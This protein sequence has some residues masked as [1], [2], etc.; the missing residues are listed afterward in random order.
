MLYG[1]AAAR[2]DRTAWNSF[3]QHPQRRRSAFGALAIAWLAKHHP[4]RSLGADAI[5]G[6]RRFSALV[7]DVSQRHSV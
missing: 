3:E 4:G 5:R 6:Q 2:A 7:R 1:A